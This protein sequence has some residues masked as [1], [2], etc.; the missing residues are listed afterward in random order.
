VTPPTEPISL[1]QLIDDCRQLPTAMLPQPRTDE[2][3]VVDLT[4][5]LTIPDTAA[6]LLDGYDP[7]Y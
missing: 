4:A 2:P 6:S 7:V 3:R 5:P 1:D